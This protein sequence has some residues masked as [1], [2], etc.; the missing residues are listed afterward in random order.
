MEDVVEA[1][2]RW[3]L[4]VVGNVIDDLDDAVWL[5]EARLEHPL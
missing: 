1:G 4:E 2:A 3:K 5:I